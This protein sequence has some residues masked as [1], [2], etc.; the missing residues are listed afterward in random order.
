MIYVYTALL[1]FEF[2]KLGLFWIAVIQLGN[3]LLVRYVISGSRI[4]IQER[5]SGRGSRRF[6]PRISRW[7]FDGRTTVPWF[8]GLNAEL[9]SIF[10]IV[11]GSGLVFVASGV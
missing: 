5:S 8:S 11:F 10:F 1:D 4:S 2:C 7:S 9:D 3:R 6:L